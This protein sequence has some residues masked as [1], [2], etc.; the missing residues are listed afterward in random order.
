MKQVEMLVVLVAQPVATSA[1]AWIGV[2]SKK[3]LRAQGRVC[4]PA[5]VM[6]HFIF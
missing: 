1:E 5:M 3:I 2:D 6:M 4:C